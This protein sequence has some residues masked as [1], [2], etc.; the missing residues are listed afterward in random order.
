MQPLTLVQVYVGLKLKIPDPMYC[1][2]NWTFSERIW[3]EPSN[4]YNTVSP[5]S[6]ILKSTNCHEL[7]MPCLSSRSV[8]I[9]YR[10]GVGG[11]NVP[12]EKVSPRG[13]YT[14]GCIVPRT[15]YPRTYCSPPGYTVP[16]PGHYNLGYIVP[17]PPPPPPPP[18]SSGGGCQNG[19]TVGGSQYSLAGCTL[20]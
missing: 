4:A 16:L 17:P 8:L 5:A 15:I 20:A 1:R 14:L 6:M 19:R 13:Q 11:Y 18:S 9:L 3:I 2:N 12:L 7:C 10:T